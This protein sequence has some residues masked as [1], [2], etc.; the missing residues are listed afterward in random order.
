[1]DVWSERWVTNAGQT[2]RWTRLLILDLKRWYSRNHGEVTFALSQALAGH[3]CFRH[4]LANF[5]IIDTPACTYGDANDDTAEH[6]LLACSRWH[7]ERTNLLL[8][9]NI[10]ELTPA[11]LVPIMLSGESEW[12]AIM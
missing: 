12:N 1:M 10:D 2:A 6:T 8:Q 4:Y 9:L 11:N 3:G 5:K 7:V